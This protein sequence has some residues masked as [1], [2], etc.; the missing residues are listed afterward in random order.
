MTTGHAR[1]VAAATF[2]AVVLG[3]C[4]GSAGGG[5]TP[6]PVA[7]SSLTATAV[8]EATTAPV[9]TAGPSPTDI[10]GGVPPTPVA[11][12]PC[13]LLTTAEASAIMGKS[14]GDGV[15]TQLDPDVVCTW[16]SGTSEVKLILAPPAPDAATAQA[17]WDA[18]KGQVPSGL[19]LNTINAFDRAAYAS[20]SAAG[21]SVSALFVIQDKWFFDLFCGF[22]ACGEAASVGGAEHIVGRLP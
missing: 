2:A 16:K 6:P 15:A 14:L 20:G 10:G 8:P 17:Y 22:P 12:D 13:S 18:A 5:A 7:L 4:S 19:K 21:V 3:A 1:L 11:V 9:T